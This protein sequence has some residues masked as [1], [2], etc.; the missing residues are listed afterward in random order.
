MRP[1][2]RWMMTD[3]LTLFNDD[4]TDDCH[5]C[6]VAAE[7]IAALK[8]INAELLSVLQELDD[9]VAYWSDYEVPLG[10]ADRIKAAIAKATGAAQ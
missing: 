5:A 1:R 7:Q 2:M 9:S 8:E 3:S 4:T 6:A 10:I